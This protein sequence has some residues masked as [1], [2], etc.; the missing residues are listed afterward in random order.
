MPLQYNDITPKQMAKGMLKELMGV[1][2]VHEFI[3][4]QYVVLMVSNITK[5]ITHELTRPQRD[6][7]LKYWN[8]VLTEL[9][10]L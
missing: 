7:R 2:R 6:E 8:N 4:K 3:G 10:A 5:E 9:D 1:F